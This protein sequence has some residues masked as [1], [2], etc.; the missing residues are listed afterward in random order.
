MNDEPS[1]VIHD[2]TRMADAKSFALRLMDE[3]VQ[4][5]FLSQPLCIS[6]P[7]RALQSAPAEQAP[8]VG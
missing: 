1:M 8:A 4:F 6:Y 5:S 3:G 7:R 2:F